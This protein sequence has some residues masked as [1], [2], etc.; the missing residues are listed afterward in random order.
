MLQSLGGT[1]KYSFKRENSMDVKV[2]KMFL[3]KFTIESLRGPVKID[4]KF[5]DLYI[6]YGLKKSET[7]I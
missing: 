1:E 5:N 2:T 6:V 7:F 3:Y 4:L